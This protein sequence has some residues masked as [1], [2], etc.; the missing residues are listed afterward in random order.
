M[1]LD[2]F[3]AVMSAASL[4]GKLLRQCPGFH[5][6]VTSQELLGVEGEQQ[7]EV[8]AMGTAASIRR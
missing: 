6:L 5:L 7:L 1:I 3:E 2:N 4:V 8:T